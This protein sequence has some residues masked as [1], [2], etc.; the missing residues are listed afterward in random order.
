MQPNALKVRTFIMVINAINHDNLGA[1]SWRG[2]VS[3]E[4]QFQAFLFEVVEAPTTLT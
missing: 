1:Y 3:A 4:G 2:L